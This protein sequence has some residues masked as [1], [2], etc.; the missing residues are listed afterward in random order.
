M[1]YT[2]KR[3]IYIVFSALAVAAVMVIIFYLSAQD[4]EESTETSSWFLDLIT[5]VFGKAPDQELLRTAAHFCEFAG[6]GLLVC[7]LIFAVKD[8]LKP[9]VSIVL[10]WL[11]AWTDEI[12][13]IFVDG[14]AFQLS[15]LAVDL[16]GIVLGTAVF[17]GIIFSINKTVRCR[18]ACTASTS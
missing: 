4:S 16:G 15:D 18:L 2:K 14:R 13:Q 10:S 11:Y 12:H 3:K 9:I 8:N 1:E 7:N 17:G 6:L 5:S